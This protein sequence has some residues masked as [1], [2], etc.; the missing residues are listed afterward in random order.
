MS[1]TEQNFAF[2]QRIARIS[3]TRPDVQP[4]KLNDWRENIW[5]PMQF[6]AAFLL[7]MV[8]V[9]VARYIRFHLGM[10]GVTGEDAG[11]YMVMDGAISF[12]VGIILWG[13]F[14]L[15]GK[16][17]KA[18]QT[19]GVIAMVVTM[20]NLVHWYPDQ[21]S[22]V[23]SPDW[24]REVIVGTEPNSFLYRGV[25]YVWDPEAVPQNLDIG[26][27]PA[28]RLETLRPTRIVMDSERQ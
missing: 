2:Q 1:R 16:E 23:F 27:E 14:R 4:V 8:T 28:G 3:Q 13:F 25:S 20:H 18:V 15:E 10:G 19:A 22:V 9:F 26:S 17:F 6:V 5:Y 12:A 21:F 11:L 24:T 7:G